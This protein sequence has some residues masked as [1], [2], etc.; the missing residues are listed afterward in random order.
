MEL[1]MKKKLLCCALLAGVGMANTAAAQSYDDRWYVGAGVGVGFFDNDREVQDTVYGMIGVGKMITPNISID[2]ELW[3]SNPD[4]TRT[5]I[6]REFEGPGD[7]GDDLDV[8]ERNWELMS[9][10]IVGRYHFI[11]EGRQWQPYIALGIGAQEH[12]DG[13]QQYPLSYGFSPS[14]TGTDVLFLAGVGATWDLGYPYLRAELGARFDNDD[15]R[16][17]SNNYVDGY[18]GFEFIVPIGAVAVPVAPPEPPPPVKTCADLDDDGDG[19]NNCDDKCPG[20]AAG[21]ALGPDG[22]PVPE[23]AP[24]PKPYRG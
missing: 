11:D 17:N 5:G 18:L 8:V 19:V 15:G 12:H 14:R 20:S 3:H 21:A 16:G 13:S 22:C 10:S 7:F 24:E 1:N 23:P 9:L 6:T 2:A 4:L